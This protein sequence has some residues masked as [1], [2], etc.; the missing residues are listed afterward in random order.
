[1][2]D[3]MSGLTADQKTQL[4]AVSETLHRSLETR[5]PRT[6]EAS[7]EPVPVHRK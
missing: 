3:L 6:E 5:R 7:G 4:A 1:M 2:Q